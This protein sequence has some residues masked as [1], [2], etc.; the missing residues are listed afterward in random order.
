M[1]VVMGVLLAVAV[2]AAVWAFMRL[3]LSEVRTEAL[4]SSERLRIAELQRHYEETRAQAEA[5]FRVLAQKILDER[6]EKLKAE[7]TAQLQGVVDPLVKGLSEFRE[8]LARNDVTLAARNAEMKERIENLLAQTGAVSSQANN[9]AAAIRGE[10]QLTGEWGECQL[11][12][13]LELS[14]LTASVDYTYQETFSDDSSGRKSKRTDVVVK[15]TGERAL[16]IDAKTTLAAAVDYREA[17]DE[18]ARAQC[19]TRL[20]E[21]LRRH[22]DEIAQANYPAAV[23]GA[24]PLV[25]MYVPLEEVYLLAMKA[26]IAVGGGRE[27]LRDYARRKGVVLVNAASVMTV[28]KLVEM[29]WSVERNE[30]NRQEIARAAAELLQRANDFVGEFL[31]VGAALETARGK[32][33]AAEKVL[34]DAPGGQSLPKAVAKLVKLGVEP[35]TRQGKAY[36][37]ADPVAEAVAQA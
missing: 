6:S 35:K 12:K 15:L 8:R 30:K 19:R 23:P 32:F 31:S 16:V 1:V 29:M 17:G 22:V 24:F 10:A 4:L 34:I 28:I 7:G 21:S 5:Q 9:L 2:G 26:Q 18:T 27:L 3:R 13:V 11:M 20:L 33:A 37:L 14:G 36:P 25:L